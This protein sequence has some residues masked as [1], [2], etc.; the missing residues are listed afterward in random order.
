MP[1]NLSANGLTV[2]VAASQTPPLGTQCGLPSGNQITSY[3]LYNDG[4]VTAFMAAAA[5]AAAAQLMAVIPIVGGPQEVY[6]VP[7]KGYLPVTDIP[8]A[9]WS[10]I[11]ASGTANVFVTPISAQNT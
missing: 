11:T 2:L 8:N 4:T 5:S 6:P 3:L 9:F 7:A 1:S 10:G